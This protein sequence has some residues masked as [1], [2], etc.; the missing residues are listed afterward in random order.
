MTEEDKLLPVYEM[1]LRSSKIFKNF[2]ILMTAKFG[3]DQIP[4]FILVFKRGSNP[5][6]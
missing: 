5:K 4:I 1:V 3:K 6:F 2:I